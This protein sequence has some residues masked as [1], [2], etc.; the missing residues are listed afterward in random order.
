[1]MHTLRPYQS[2]SPWERFCAWITST[3]NRLYVGWFGTLLI[4]T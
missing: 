2:V 4:P 3:E 1:M